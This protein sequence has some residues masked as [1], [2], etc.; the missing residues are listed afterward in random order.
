LQLHAVW[1][2]RAIQF[3]AK[4]A[5]RAASAQPASAEVSAQAVD[6]L[7]DRWAYDKKD[8]LASG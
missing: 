7:V 4:W 2:E 1:V 8:L 3:G 5:D 6:A